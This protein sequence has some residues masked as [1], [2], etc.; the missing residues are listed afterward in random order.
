MTEVTHK[1]IYNQLK[2]IFDGCDTILDAMPFGNYYI[3]KYPHMKSMITSYMNGRSYK[4][5]VD[6]K[7]KQNF[8]RDTDNFMSRDEALHFS[9]KLTEKTTDDIYKKTLERIVNS[10]TF[11][12]REFKKDT[13]KYINK[14]C[15][16]CSHILSMPESTQYVICGYHNPNQGY[17]WIGCGKDWCFQCE[18]ILCKRWEMNSLCL[19]MNRYHNDECCSKHAKETGHKYPDDY[20]QCNNINIFNALMN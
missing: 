6:I 12:K 9:S 16:H 17:D 1:D 4:D 19:Q 13:V 18:K 3:E 7:T 10:K 11:K 5:V 2:A 15:P 14:E 20:C 8:M